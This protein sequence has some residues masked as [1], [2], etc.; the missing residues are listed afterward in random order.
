MYLRI[1]IIY[2]IWRAI[3]NS[4]AFLFIYKLKYL[5]IY[6]TLYLIKNL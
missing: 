6:A 4:I 5:K 1:K 2:D 3:G